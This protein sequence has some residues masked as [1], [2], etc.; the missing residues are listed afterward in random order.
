MFLNNVPGALHDRFINEDGHTVNMLK[1]QHGKLL[2]ST[3]VDNP[4]VTGSLPHG[5]I[6]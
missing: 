1:L 5:A 6:P 4:K 2:T 3:K